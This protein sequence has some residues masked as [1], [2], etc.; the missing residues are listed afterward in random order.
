MKQKKKFIIFGQSRSGSTLLKVLLNSHPGIHCE[1]ELFNPD[2]GYVSNPW[3]LRIIRRFP[4]TYINYR[5]LICKNEI[6]GFTLF[7]YHLRNI[8]W[9]LNKFEEKGWLLIYIERKNIFLQVL[10]DLIAL[11][12]GYW[13]RRKKDLPPD[14]RVKIEPGKVMQGLQKRMRWHQFE[15]GLLKKVP[16]VKVIYEEDLQDNGIWD[17]SLQ[18]DFNFLGVKPCHVESNLLKTDPRPL[19]E[20][21]ENYNELAEMLKNTAFAHLIPSIH[22]KE[23]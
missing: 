15:D 8:E 18:K 11:K 6:Y 3:A 5:K 17:E 22:E 2:D 20:I 16:H 1:G 12:T 13:H 9:Y 23:V 10:S 7:Q 14:Y 19:H 21:I 4:E